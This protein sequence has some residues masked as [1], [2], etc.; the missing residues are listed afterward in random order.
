MATKRWIGNAAN[1]AQ[2][3][4]VVFADVWASGDTCTATVNSKALVVTMGSAITDKDEAATAFQKAW[5]GTAS[6]TNKVVPPV[7]PTQWSRQ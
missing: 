1:V 4:S 2:V 6:G 3:D 7:G 5:N